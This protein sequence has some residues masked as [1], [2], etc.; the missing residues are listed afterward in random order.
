ML[1]NKTFTVSIPKPEDTETWP[2][3][4]VEIGQEVKCYVTHIDKNAKLPFICATL[5][6]DYLQ[7]CRLPHNMNNIED[8]KMIIER[9]TL[10]N[11]NQIVDKSSVAETENDTIPH[12]EK[13]KS[14][15]RKRSHETDL[16]PVRKIE[17]D[18]ESVNH[19]NNIEDTE[20]ITERNTLDNTNQIVD[21]LSVAAT[22][23]DTIPHKKGKKH[24]KRKKSHVTDLKSVFK[25]ERDIESVNHMNNIEDTEM[26]TER[27]TLDNVNQIV[28]KLN[29]IARE[30]VTTTT[31][32]ERKKSS[33]RKRSETD[34]KPVCKI[35]PDTESVNDT[36]NHP[37]KKIKYEDKHENTQNNISNNDHSLID[38]EFDSVPTKRKKRKKILKELS[39][40][41][42]KDHIVKV[43]N[44]KPE[45]ITNSPIKKSTANHVELRDVS[46]ILERC[47]SV[48][49]SI[50]RENSIKD[51]FESQNKKTPKKHRRK[52]NESDSEPVSIKKIRKVNNTN[53]SFGMIKNNNEQYQHIKHETTYTDTLS[54]NT[55]LDCISK[56]PK[57]WKISLKMPN[58]KIE[59]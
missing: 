32:E 1:V 54:S 16:K 20:M 46:I 8:T 22:E 19:M 27:N 50:K 52:T 55:D 12:K 15:K 31:H 30:K 13:K 44:E 24:S 51:I 40:L 2:G 37:L 3:D 10:D 26:V 43:K 5:D 21:K 59:S 11:V 47:T 56:K 49:R 53:N 7:N 36:V 42:L 28:D 6:L 4:S 23:N 33:K 38:S 29:V 41:E 34:L 48:E 18:V 9:N 45:S 57:K 25:V 14:S 17:H 35:E 39:D 58:R